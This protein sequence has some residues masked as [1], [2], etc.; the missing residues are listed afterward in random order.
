MLS[1]GL[2]SLSV[3]EKRDV[4]TI[5]RTIGNFS[6]R[7]S[8]AGNLACGRFGIV[9]ISD[10]AMASNVTPDPIGDSE[11]SWLYNQAFFQEDAANVPVFFDFDLK[12]KRRL[13]GDG[14]TLV[15][16]CESSSQSVGSFIVN[17]GIR[18]LYSFN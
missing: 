16:I 2:G 17:W 6:I 10:D 15:I 3:A 9:R 13:T 12:G 18:F 8:T 11:S 4:R 1:D 7:S 14:Q 5:L